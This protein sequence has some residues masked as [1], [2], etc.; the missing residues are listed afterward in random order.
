LTTAD[1]KV[2]IKKLDKETSYNKAFRLETR[3]FSL[4][5]LK[6]ERELSPLE[7]KSLERLKRDLNSVDEH[8]EDL[9]SK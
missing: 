1:A 6:E 7:K 2:L 8:I 3:I 9:E 5:K 4:M